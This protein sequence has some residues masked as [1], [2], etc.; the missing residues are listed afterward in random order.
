[1]DKELKEQTRARNLTPFELK[2]FK[3][4]KA[5]RNQPNRLGIG[6]ATLNEG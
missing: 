6:V 5:W 2:E 4:L 1:M 3:Q